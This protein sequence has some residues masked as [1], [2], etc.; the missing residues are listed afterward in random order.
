MKHS[1]KHSRRGP[2]R[3]RAGQPAASPTRLA[4]ERLGGGAVVVLDPGLHIVEATPEA[5]RLLGTPP[6]GALAPKV[7]C[8]GSER[9]PVA[10]ALAAGRAADVVIPAPTGRGELRVIATPLREGER[11]AGH[12]LQ[13]Q[14]SGDDAE[15]TNV[16]GMWT[17]DPAMKH[18]FQLL[19]KV[20][21][22]DATVLVRGESGTG[23]ELVAR[24]IH[25][26][27]PHA[28]GPFHAVSCAAIPEALLESELFGHV[29]GSFT[30][31]VRDY[32]GHFRLADGGTLM[33][34]EVAELPLGTQA[35]LLRVLETHSVLPVGGR[36]SI[37]VNVRVIAATHRAL[38]KEVEAGRF[39]A[40]LMFRLRVIPVFLPPLRARQKDIA[41]LAEKIIEEL[42]ARSARKV[43]RLS[44]DARAALER[45]DFPGNVRELRNIL[46]YAFVV[47]EG[48][49]IERR[50]LPPEIGFPEATADGAPRDHVR[51]SPSEPSDAAASPEAARIARALERASGNKSRAARALGMSR[52]TLWRHMKALGLAG[53]G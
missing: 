23:K 34:D 45:H 29:R 38:R 11:L 5:D 16:A 31:A 8:G 27:S 44:D 7:L 42:N 39:R 47:G 9:R 10:E 28:S 3:V 36:E 21:A 1:M 25:A 13:F 53:G 18:M 51:P 46:E 35:K 20:A 49:L 40:D 41:L 52:V 32:P 17:R 30:G 12:V 22:S 6:R 19:R 43:L 26:F 48:P 33:L 15:V 14:A 50:D 4:L 24:A 37:R 2:S